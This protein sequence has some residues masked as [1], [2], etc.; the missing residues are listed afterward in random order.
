MSRLAIQHFQLA[1]PYYIGATVTFYTAV[2]GAAT[3]VL[4]T[5]YA[6]M[7]G[8]QR[9]NNPQT[10]DAEGKFSAPVY[11]DGSVVGVVTGPRV[12]SHSTGVFGAASYTT[13]SAAQ[14]NTLSPLTAAPFISF[15]RT[16]N[17]AGTTYPPGTVGRTLD[18]INSVYGNVAN[19]EYAVAIQAIQ[20]SL[21]TTAQDI[22][23]LNATGVRALAALGS[24]NGIW[25]GNI[26]AIDD[27]ARK[28]SLTPEYLRG[29]E[30]NTSAS[31]PDDA[32]LRVGID[33]IQFERSTSTD[34]ATSHY[35]GVRVIPASAFGTNHGQAPVTIKNGF[36]I[37]RF[38]TSGL[39]DVQVGFGGN[40]SLVNFISQGAAPS[41][42][43]FYANH[44]LSSAWNA[45]VVGPV[46]APGAVIRGDGLVAL[47][48]VAGLTQGLNVTQTGSG[49]PATSYSLNRFTISGDAID[50][51]TGF[52]DGLTLI[53]SFGGS[54]AKGGR[55]SLDVL[56]S[57]DAATSS[58]NGNRFYAAAVFGGQ[59]Q[60]SD[61]GNGGTSRG[62]IFAANAYVLLKPAA[63]FMVEAAISEWNTRLQAGS[64]VLDKY[65]FKIVQTADDA[66][67]GSRNDAALF[68]G[69]Q[70]GAVGWGELIKLGDG[71]NAAPLKTTGSILT[72]KGAPTFANG[73]DLRGTGGGST[74]SGLAFASP[75]FSVSGAGAI[76][77]LSPTAGIGYGTGAGGTVTQATSKTTGVT[78]NKI[79]G[80][81]V[82]NNSSL[83]DSTNAGFTLTN[84][85]ITA[86]DDVRVW[87]KSGGTDFAYAPWCAGTASGSC[88]LVIRNVSG[89]SLSEAVT[90]GFAV[91]RVV[92][93]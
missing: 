1:N 67:A 53:H 3:E 23:A 43:S 33:V 22:S 36:I 31:G 47:T 32:N 9:L 87:V 2:D 69:N 15:S 42:A 89:G 29:L 72:I 39:G 65:G 91:E 66:V 92:V 83:A 55:Q 76:S 60:A 28:S 56:M 70:I 90:L 63:T 50:A 84:S 51:G 6:G 93:A 5:L 35:A 75:N 52:V 18:I 54:A 34:G 8:T 78:L 59:A 85:T 86:N 80:E 12:E 37:D 19:F 71:V 79:C 82:L 57:L 30:V 4:A 58:S 13:L 40:A 88:K 16:T 74:V 49:A 61:G 24:V 48:P 46:G 45:L 64:S 10:L 7:T 27:T 62:S 41:V 20:N 44:A 38:G 25:G 68:F 11:I 77:S 21:I 17:H 14:T 73:I 81:I 26:L